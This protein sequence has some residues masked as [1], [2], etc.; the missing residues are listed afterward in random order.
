MRIAVINI[1]AGGMSGGYRKYLR[2]VIPRMANHEDVESILCASPESIGI[3]GWFDSISNIRCVNCKP[4]RF[5]LPH[6]DTG[7]FREHGQ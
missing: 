1:T 4:F 6:R 2:N 5:M 3:S 7:M